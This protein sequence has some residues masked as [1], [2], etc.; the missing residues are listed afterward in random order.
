MNI[1][2]ITENLIMDGTAN[3]ITTMAF[4]D[5]RTLLR[6]HDFNVSKKRVMASM[7]LWAIKYA[8]K[9]RLIPDIEHVEDE[10]EFLLRRMVD[11]GILER[12]V[13]DAGERIYLAVSKAVPTATSQDCEVLFW[14]LLRNCFNADSLDLEDTKFKH[15]RAN[16]RAI[17]VG[18]ARMGLLKDE[19]NN[20]TNDH[21]AEA[22]R[23]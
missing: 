14:G 16:L 5:A 15:S 3:R 20:R 18:Q 6:E 17:E 13:E 23:A 7:K 4:I 22:K 21:A 2:T 9:D 1:N 10:D 19:N 8:T 12:I 11:L